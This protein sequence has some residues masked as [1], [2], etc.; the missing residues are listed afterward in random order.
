MAD[1]PAPW[2]PEALAAL[3]PLGREEL[4]DALQ[5][6]DDRSS[7]YEYLVMA[8][9]KQGDE[10]GAKKLAREWLTY[11]DREARAAPNPEART[12]LD[13]HRLEAALDLGDP[14]L[15]VPALLQS[16]R[17]LPADFNPPARLAMAYRELGRY[18][19]ALAESQRALARAVGPRRLRILSERAAVFEKQGDRAA[20][21]KTLQ[22]A[23]DLA[24]TMP[25]AQQPAGEIAKI[26]KA[27]AAS[28][29]Q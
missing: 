3:E 11:L 5:L 16:E 25:A 12:A 10:P 28:Q 9:R 21:A 23:L 18:P 29:T 1:D 19:E 14:A 20:R 7:L 2:R 4:P 26:R 8:L 13:G 17:E 22:Q 27:L 15:A 6:A 24:A